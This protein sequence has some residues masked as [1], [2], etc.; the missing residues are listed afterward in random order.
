MAA[1]WVVALAVVDPVLLTLTGSD[2]VYELRNIGLFTITGTESMMF[3]YPL[4]AAL[5]LSG[6]IPVFAIF[7]Y[8]D[9][10]LQMKVARF[11]MII[12]LVYVVLLVFYVDRANTLIGQETDVVASVWVYSALIPIIC[13]FL[14]GKFIKKDEALVRA[15]D[16]LR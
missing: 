3:T 7:K 12:Q 2:A 9:R 5:A 4:L 8:A 15:A 13:S 11:G 16:R 10:K 14:A 6:V 1:L